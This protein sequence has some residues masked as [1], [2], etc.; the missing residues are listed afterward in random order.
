MDV[1]G[2]Y[3]ADVALNNTLYATVL[4]GSTHITSVS[5]QMDADPPLAGMKQTDDRW[6]ATFDMG[7][8]EGGVAHTLTVIATD[9]LGNASDP[10]ELTIEVIPLPSWPPD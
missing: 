6:K 4:A 10:K 7:A 9:S 8:L 2:R 5:F 3:L 1:A